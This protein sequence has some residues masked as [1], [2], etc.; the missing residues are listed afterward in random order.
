MHLDPKLSCG[1]GLSK[2]APELERV[3]AITRAVYRSTEGVLLDSSAVLVV[4]GA[5]EPSCMAH[6]DLGGASSFWT[7]GPQE[8]GPK[9][10][11]FRFQNTVYILAPAEPT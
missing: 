9:Y 2:P 5:P 11:I 7:A 6:F 10:S 4:R 8:G 3:A 1:D